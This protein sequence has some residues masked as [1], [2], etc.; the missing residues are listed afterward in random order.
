MNTKATLSTMDIDIWEHQNVIKPFCYHIQHSEKQ[1]FV[2]ATPEIL[3]ITAQSLLDKILVSFNFIKKE[4]AFDPMHM[5]M[6]IIFSVDLANY[7]TGETRSFACW[8]DC[9]NMFV[10]NT[11]LF[12]YPC[13]KQVARSVEYKRVIWNEI[14]AYLQR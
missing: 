14:S 1:G 12:V 2:L 5:D 9:G 4:C 11:Q 7:I 3:C 10:G 8:Q 6:F 13:L